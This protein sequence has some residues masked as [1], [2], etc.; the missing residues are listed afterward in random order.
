[1]SWETL[2]CPPN[3]YFTGQIKMKHF[4]SD[5]FKPRR[6]VSF[7]WSY[8]KYSILKWHSK[9]IMA[10]S[11]SHMH[12]FSTQYLTLWKTT[13]P[14]KNLSQQHQYHGL[15]E[16]FHPIIFEPTSPI[17]SSTKQKKRDPDPQYLPP[18]EAISSAI[19]NVAFK[20]LSAPLI[21]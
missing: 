4:L 17:L 11:F 14:I 3:G 10:N 13:S 20:S 5:K 7:C 21:I 12:L 2:F 16:P 8:L 18:P 9:N 1:M 15:G 6:N 19:S